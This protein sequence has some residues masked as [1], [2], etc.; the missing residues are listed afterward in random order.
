ATKAGMAASGVV[1]VVYDIYDSWRATGALGS[2]S[3][4]FAYPTGVA[5]DAAGRIYVADYGNSRIV[6]MDDMSGAQWTA[7]GAYGSGAGHFINPAGI[8]VDSGGDIYVA[9]SGNN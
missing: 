7:F 2:G 5:L 6:R 8:A 3:S 1:S 9:D 4:Q